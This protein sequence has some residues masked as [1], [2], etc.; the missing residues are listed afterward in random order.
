MPYSSDDV[1]YF[2]SIEIRSSN[3]LK[4]SLLVWDH[5]YRIVPPGYEP[6]DN[7]QARM[8]VDA[9]L[10]RNLTIEKDDRDRAYRSFSRII[11]R[12]P[13]V[14]HGFSERDIDYVHTGKI[15]ERLHSL[16]ENSSA[17]LHGDW[18]QMPRGL[19]KGYMLT[20]ARKAAQRRGL[21]LTTDSADA[22]TADA[23]LHTRGNLD[24]HLSDEESEEQFCHA[25]INDLLPLNL[26]SIDMA[27]IL[28][29]RKTHDDERQ[30]LRVEIGRTLTSLTRCESPE[31]ARHIVENA[32]KSLEKRKL[33]YKR[34]IRAFLGEFSTASLI[35]GVPTTLTALSTFAM[36]DPQ[37]LKKIGGALVV[38][39]VAALADAQRARTQRRTDQIGSYLVHVEDEDG[40]ASHLPHFPRLMEEFVND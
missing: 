35:V 15:D 26:A 36:G 10:L 24:E 11:S 3:W 39:S 12:A 4:A 21:S 20:L 25:I 14:P 9:G 19:A 18:Y 30:A 16:L 29:L 6:H 8:A 2:P 5:I 1:L 38:G 32:C 17:V 33:A 34:G 22:W 40:T 27:A 28:R 31:Y 7:R 37:D 23:Y 13:F